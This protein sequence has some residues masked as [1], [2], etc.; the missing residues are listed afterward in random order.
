MSRAFR[1]TKES[2]T[3]SEYLAIKTKTKCHQCKP[4]YR[5]EQNANNLSVN[6]ITK[7]DLAYIEVVNGNGTI[8]PNGSLFGN[9]PCETQD[10]LRYLVAL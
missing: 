1:V 9:R 3:A 7:L 5:N 2:K 8:D 10:Y 4:V 6:L